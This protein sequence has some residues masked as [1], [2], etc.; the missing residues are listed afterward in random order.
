VYVEAQS[1]K[2]RQKKKKMFFSH[3]F[4]LASSSLNTVVRT[5]CMHCYM[6]LIE[7][8]PKTVDCRLGELCGC[9]A[10]YCGIKCLVA[11]AQAHKV[12]CE[13]NQLAL[14]ALARDRFRANEETNQLALNADGRV[15][16]QLL[17][18]DMLV[19]ASDTVNALLDAAKGV[20]SAEAFELAQKMAQRALSLA[21]KGSLNEATALVTLGEVAYEMSKY[22]AALA[23]HEAALKI[24][25]HL[26]G[27]NHADV[28]RSFGNLSNVFQKLGRS[29]EA[30]AMCSS[31]LEIFNKAPGDNQQSIA[32]CHQGMGNLFERARQVRGGDGALLGRTRDHFGDRRRDCK[33]C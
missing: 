13:G 9:G 26:L 18:A 3:F 19:A 17:R 32:I 5:F 12:V 11:D 29:D 28:G 33:R 8:S 21:A 14:Q 7:A 4:C 25:K 30:L 24:R 31:A 22:D 16:I 23:H 20:L 15:Q 2:P 10:R 27:D 1:T 6:A